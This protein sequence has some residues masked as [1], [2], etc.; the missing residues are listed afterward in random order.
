MRGYLCPSPSLRLKAVEST[1]SR[2]QAQGGVA[3]W[4]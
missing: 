2:F 3:W 1:L 4:W